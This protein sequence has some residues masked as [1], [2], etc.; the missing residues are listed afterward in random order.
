MMM[1][2]LMVEEWRLLGWNIKVV[3][4]NDFDGAF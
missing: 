4:I 3:D 2:E 1:V